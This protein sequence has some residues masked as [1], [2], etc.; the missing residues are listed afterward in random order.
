MSVLQV[1]YDWMYNISNVTSLGVYQ[2]VYVS[3]H[4][5]ENVYEPTSFTINQVIW[6]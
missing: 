1:Q 6:H 4:M 5:Y 2:Y 3:E